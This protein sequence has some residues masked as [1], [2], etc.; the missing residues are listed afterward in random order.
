LTVTAGIGARIDEG[1]NSTTVLPITADSIEAATITVG[2]AAT[3]AL[4]LLYGGTTTISMTTGSTLDLGDVG[5]ASTASSTTLTGRG[6]LQGALD[7]LGDA[8]FN[9]SGLE[10]GGS[11]T[12]DINDDSDD[13]TVTTNR[14]DAVLDA[15]A[16]GD[17]TLTTGAGDDYVYSDNGGTK[18]SY[19]SA[20]V[21][22]ISPIGIAT[23]TVAFRGLSTSATTTTVT[24]AGLVDAIE[25]AVAADQT[26]AGILS[27][28]D[29][30]LGAVSFTSLVEGAYAVKPVVTI[31]LSTSGSA[32][33]TAGTA[34]AGADGTGGDDTVRTNDGIDVV[35]GGAGDDDIGTGAGADYIIAGAGDDTISAGSGI[36]IIDAGAGADTISGGTGLDVF[37]TVAGDAVPTIGGTGDAGTITGYD[38]ISDYALGTA[39]TNAETIDFADVTDAVLS[40]GATDGTDSTLT[41]GGVAVKSHSIA[42]GI[43]TFDDADTYAAALTID[44]V[45]DIAAVVQ[46]LQANDL[47]NA[48]ATVA[49]TATLSG[50]TSTFVFQQG[51]D[52]GTNTADNLIQLTGV[53][54][55][56]MSAT[57]ATTAGLIDIGA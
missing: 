52:A 3:A 56:S 11:V 28:T 50:T 40:D 20:I 24:A 14:Y 49:F 1:T 44:S 25:A 4:D 53:T 22:T 36:D 7:L 39:S 19:A 37:R 47:G 2:A 57:N 8:T 33:L 15:A 23:V 21:G 31:A 16:G 55:L 29:G 43:V 6:T 54:G 9:F 45:A 17:D 34:T 10:T 38:V 26:M 5:V 48:G 42:S 18:T 41:I 35:S 30:T 51:A 27:V 12:L 46:Y 13:K 32:T